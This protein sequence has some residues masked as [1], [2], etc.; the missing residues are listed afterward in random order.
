MYHSY[1]V[2]PAHPCRPT[3]EIEAVVREGDVDSGPLLLS[4]AECATLAGGADVVRPCLDRLRSSGRIVDH[5]GVSY[6]SFP[7]WTPIDLEHR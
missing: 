2:D 7:T 5:L 3:L 4:V 1:A 6:V